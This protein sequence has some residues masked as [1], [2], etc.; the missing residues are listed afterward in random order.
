M[1]HLYY[2]ILTKNQGPFKKK[3]KMCLRDRREMTTGEQCLLN[4]TECLDIWTHSSCYS[5][6]KLKLD[7]NPSMKMAGRYKVPSLPQ[8][9]LTI[10]GCWMKESIFFRNQPHSSGRLRIQQYMDYIG[11]D[12][13]GS[14]N[15][16]GP[17]GSKGVVLLERIKMSGFIRRCMSLWVCFEVPEAQAISSGPLSLPTACWLR[18]KTTNYFSRATL[19]CVPLCFLSWHYW[20]I[21]LKLETIPK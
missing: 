7:K 9:V 8:K 4:I 13:C 18:W 10:Y 1:E 17:I 12:G 19:T 11:L 15:E 21:P 20:S 16:Y 5:M 14:L 6:H 2:I 3:R